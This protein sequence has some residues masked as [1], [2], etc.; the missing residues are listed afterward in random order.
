[1]LAVDR[2]GLVGDDGET[3]QGVFDVTYLNSIPGI[4]VYA[5][6][7]FVELERMLQEAVY[8]VEGPVAIRYPRGGQGE[9]KRDTGREPVVTLRAGKDITLAG[10]GMEINDLLD[11]ADRLRVRG[12]EAEVLKWNII[13]P[14]T[15]EPVVNS[16]QKTGHFV[17]AE[18]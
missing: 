17:V 15:M 2:A 12:V 8:Q 11:A 9:F 13:T 7:N 14:L 3:H 10:Y 6:A 5:P 16:V 1:M 4:T 18:E